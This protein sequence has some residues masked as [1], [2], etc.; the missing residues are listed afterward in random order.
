MNSKMES[1]KSYI[2]LTKVLGEISCKLS[3]LSSQEEIFDGTGWREFRRRREAEFDLFEFT[4]EQK[5]RWLVAR[6]TPRV[7]EKW[8]N[9]PRRDEEGKVLRII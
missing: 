8:A 9:I 2:L 5:V 4:S 1:E 6:L 3:R 7:K